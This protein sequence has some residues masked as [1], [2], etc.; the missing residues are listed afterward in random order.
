M[1]YFVFVLF[2]CSEVSTSEASTEA[3]A[4][5]E[6]STGTTTEAATST[7]SALTITVTLTHSLG[8]L[9]HL[10]QLLGSE[11][12][13]E[14]CTVFLLYVQTKLL[15]LNL[16]G[17]TGEH[18]VQLGCCLLVGEVF[19]G[20]FLAVISLCTGGCEFFEIALVDSFELGL[21]FALKF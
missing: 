15:L 6:A 9:E 18:L 12:G 21:L 3:T 10:E 5:A 7:L 8:L 4:S 13:R 20:T 2:S 19:L 17:L 16:L 14:F 1:K 11:Y